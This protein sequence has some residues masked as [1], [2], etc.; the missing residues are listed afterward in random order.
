M[1][2]RKWTIGFAAIGLTFAVLGGSALQVTAAKFSKPKLMIGREQAGLK[3]GNYNRAQFNEPYSAVLHKGNLYVTD[4]GNHCIRFVDL[5]RKYVSM[6]TGGNITDKD[7]ELLKGYRDSHISTAKF[8]EPRGI[9]VDKEGVIYVADTGNHVIRKIKNDK[10]YTYTGTGKA[11]DKSNN[12][13]DSEFNR[14]SDVAILGDSIYIADTLNSAIKKIDK[15]GKVVTVLQGN[16]LI[17]PVGLTSYKNSLYITDSGAQRIFK[18]REGKGISVV[19]GEKSSLDSQTG[20]RKWGLKDGKAKSAL[21]NFPKAVAMDKGSLLVA[22]TW[23]ARVRKIKDGKV[24][25]L[26]KLKGFQARPTKILTT[27]KEMLIIDQANNQI[28]IYK[29]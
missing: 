17:E 25:T 21:F 20:Y 10:V 4:S 28:L 13:A 19:A 24:K 22:D 5:K 2:M 7:P 12:L 15:Q 23:N 16:M 11:G 1:R 8:N 14:P 18:Y 6:Y 26:I 3:D 27:K 29:K 9:A